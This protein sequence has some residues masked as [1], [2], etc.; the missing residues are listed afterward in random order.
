MADTPITAANVSPSSSGRKL[1]VTGVLLALAGPAGY[2]ALIAAHRLPMP[3]FLPI[4]ATLGAILIAASLWRA[5]RVGRILAL[6]VVLL[7]TGFEWMFVFAT[8]LPAYTGP[9]AIGQPFP[10]FTTTRADGTTFTDDDLR[11]GQ[12]N[13]LVFFRG[14]W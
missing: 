8:R 12:T 11:G 3:W 5:R 4:S 2:A 7:L 1:V 14:R 6:V 9:V 13:V 10:S